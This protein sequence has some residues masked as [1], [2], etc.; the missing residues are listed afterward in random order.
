MTLGQRLLLIAQLQQQ[1][2]DVGDLP[3]PC[4]VDFPLARVGI[5]QCRVAPALLLYDAFLFARLRASSASRFCRCAS[6]SG[7]STCLTVAP[8]LFNSR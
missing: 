3:R 6:V 4:R 8:C 5:E 1:F 7:A 2:L